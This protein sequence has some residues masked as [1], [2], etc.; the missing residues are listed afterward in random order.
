MPKRGCPQLLT[1][2][3]MIARIFMMLSASQFPK[4]F[5]RPSKKKEKGNHAIQTHKHVHK[6]RHT[7]THDIELDFN[8][9]KDQC[10]RLP[11]LWILGSLPITLKVVKETGSLINFPPRTGIAQ[12]STISYT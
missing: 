5:V 3:A 12:L 10:L 6:R 9:V 4:I 2:S 11:K 7:H 1:Q 8:P